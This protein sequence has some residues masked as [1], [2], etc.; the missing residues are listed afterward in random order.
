MKA[1]II[2]TAAILLL[3]IFSWIYSIY[4]CN[5]LDDILTI[6]SNLP[7]DT[8]PTENQL[9]YLDEAEALWKD[10]HILL[11]LFVNDRHHSSAELAFNELKEYARG[12]DLPDYLCAKEAFSS[13]IKDII[14]IEGRAFFSIF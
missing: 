1:F 8:L 13:S 9:E 11:Q 14:A 6:V 12:H 7:K 5:V 4:I 10:H 2:S 3:L